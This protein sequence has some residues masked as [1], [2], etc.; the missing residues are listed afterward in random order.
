[1]TK[2][3]WTLVLGLTCSLAIAASADAKKPPLKRA[4]QLVTTA[5]VSSVMGRGMHKTADAPTGCAWQAGPNAQASLELYGWKKLSDAKQYFAGKVKGY[6]FCVDQPDHFLP[7]SG[8]GDDAWL[9]ACASNVAFRLG[10]I[11]GE[12]TTFTQDVEQG[13]TG[14]TRRTSKL[15]R[16]IVAHL[17]KL[18]C[19]AFCRL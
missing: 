2:L 8:L 13:S 18:R 10:R 11:T 1:V 9:D 17:R 19:A 3:T 5:Q 15:T 16:K 4:C 6:E 14:D 7:H 12:V